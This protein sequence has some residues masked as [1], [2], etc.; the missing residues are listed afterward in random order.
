MENSWLDEDKKCSLTI[1]QCLQHETEPSYC[2]IAQWI[3]NVIHNIG[4][5]L[6]VLDSE[7]NIKLSNKTAEEL[8][9]YYRMELYKKPFVELL[10]PPYRQK[11]MRNFL[12]KK[13][14]N[15][16]NQYEL[17]GQKKDKTTFFME[18][19]TSEVV[20]QEGK[21][22][23]VLVRDIRERKALEKAALEASE[24]ER[25]RIGQDIHDSLCQLLI[26]IEFKA[27]FLA[28]ELHEKT[29]KG[30]EL[31]TEIAK[32]ARQ[33]ATSARDIAKGL[34]PLAM[35]TS[36]LISSL[37]DLSQ[38]TSKNTHI[39]CQFHLIGE[40][41]IPNPSF[42]IQIYRIAQEAINNAIKHS[43]ATQI[44]ITFGE[45]A[46]TIFLQVEDNGMGMKI[47][48][49]LNKGLGFRSMLYRAA[50][51]GAN[52]TI[53]SLPGKGTKVICSLPS[54]VKSKTESREKV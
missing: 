51:I 10:A 53:D 28:Q 8:F 54:F 35:T 25:Q 41:I 18:I 12:S 3:F 14:K 11:W 19:S 9:G 17:L 5:G 34:A 46:G 47:K 48:E 4:E 42:I 26:G 23:S 22:V 30:K 27:Q 15:R 31:A 40:P 7:G 16:I 45:T 50:M 44:N 37:M 33:A 6:L 21:I 49:G 38:N 13:K 24:Q 32:L 29:E 43:Q 52:L 2:S 39:G 20:L 1:S 36:D